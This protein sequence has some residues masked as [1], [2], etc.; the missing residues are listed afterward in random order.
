MN[1]Q[2]RNAPA[3]VDDRLTEFADLF[4]N[5]LY[6]EGTIIDL[7]TRIAEI[8]AILYGEEAADAGF[9]TMFRS[10]FPEL[11]A[12]GGWRH[13]I[14]EDTSGLLP[15]T[16]FGQL[17]TDLALYAD[18]GIVG[19]PC[20]DT[21]QR[22]AI[23]DEHVTMATRL[24]ELAPEDLWSLKY[25]DALR[26]IRKAGARWKLDNGDPVNAV[27]LALLSGKALQTIRNKLAGKPQEIVGNQ[28]RIDAPEALG[29]LTRVAGFKDSIW[30]SQDN[31]YWVDIHDE[32][33][34]E[35]VFVPVAADGSVFHPSLKKDDHFRIGGEGREEQVSGFDEA[36]RKLQAEPTPQ[37]RRPT[38]GGIWTRVRATGWQRMTTR[39]LQALAHT[40]AETTP[41]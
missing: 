1:T 9:D 30:Q 16:R 8:C 11:V 32:P 3:E 29:W 12:E 19:T 20:R 23:L 31:P 22:R 39:D 34:E 18:Y 33:L 4:G 13:A 2:T 6:F 38:K 21:E 25:K 26:L 40:A 15:E 17:L 36:L 41:A 37:W 27:E 5:D 24:L 7:T 35:I 28:S 10:S 14:E